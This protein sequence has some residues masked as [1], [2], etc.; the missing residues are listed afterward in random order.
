[1]KKYYFLLIALI[2]SLYA[3]GQPVSTQLITPNKVWHIEHA[4]DCY[5]ITGEITDC[6]CHKYR[7]NKSR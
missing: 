4:M 7:N 3:F 6:F 1:M 2:L 5:S